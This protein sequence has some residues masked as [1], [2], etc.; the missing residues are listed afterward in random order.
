MFADGQANLNKGFTGNEQ[1]SHTRQ[2]QGRNFGPERFGC[3]PAC[4][5]PGRKRYNPAFQAESFSPAGLQMRQRF[6]D[7]PSQA[8]AV[9]LSFGRTS[10]NSQRINVT[11]SAIQKKS[12]SPWVALFQGLA[13]LAW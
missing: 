9:L 8:L 10:R 2:P 13:H 3:G 4:W 5:S 1:K 7:G 6:L 12:Y 11:G